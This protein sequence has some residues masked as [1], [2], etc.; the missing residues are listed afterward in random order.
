MPYNQIDA[1]G[2]IVPGTDPAGPN[3]KEIRD[4]IEQA[5]NTN[6]Y[7]F[8]WSA[9]NKQPYEGT[10]DT[11]S[12]AVNLLIYAWRISNGG[13][14]NLPSEKRI[15]IPQ[16]VDNIGFLRSITS[17]QKTLL[18]GIYDCPTGT[19]I[20]AAWDATANASHTQK[21]CLQIFNLNLA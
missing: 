14:A 20:F 5:L 15:Q 8:S 18:L 3:R 16:T 13:R 10:L 11:G 6:D 4:I 2:R 17:T 21:S 7:S 19:P 9:R 1:T 12:N